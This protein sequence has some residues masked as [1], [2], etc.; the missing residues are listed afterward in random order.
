MGFWGFRGGGIKNNLGDWIKKTEM[1]ALKRR[2]NEE[3]WCFFYGDWLGGWGVMGFWGFRGGGIKKKLG[4]EIK[5]SGTVVLKRRKNE[6]FW[7]IFYG[8]WLSGWGV[9]VVWLF[10]GGD[11]SFGLW[12]VVFDVVDAWCLMNKLTWA[13]RMVLA[14]FSAYYK[15]FFKKKKTG[16]VRGKPGVLHSATRRKNRV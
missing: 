16:C 2:K 7:C 4:D 11:D 12:W 10:R 1:V 9:I 14:G 3:F 5:K 13:R 15:F 8:D 6:E